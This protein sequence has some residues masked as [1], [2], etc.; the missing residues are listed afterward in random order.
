MM[1]VSSRERLAARQASRRQPTEG[2]LLMKRVC[3]YVRSVPVGTV[4]LPVLLTVLCNYTG[5]IQIMQK[6]SNLEVTIPT[7]CY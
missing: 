1:Q 4:G 7:N 6:E 2:G 3:L 5:M